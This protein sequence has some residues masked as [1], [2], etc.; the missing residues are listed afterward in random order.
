MNCQICSSECDGKTKIKDARFNAPFKD[1][2]T[3]CRDCFNLW[4]K[5]DDEKLIKRI[6]LKIFGKGIQG[7]R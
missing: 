3:I 2:A 6:K 1:E 4:I 5:A 7:L